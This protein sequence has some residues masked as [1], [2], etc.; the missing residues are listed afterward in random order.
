[1]AEEVAWWPTASCARFCDMILHVQYL[2]SHGILSISSET[3]TA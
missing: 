2:A 1:M 3:R